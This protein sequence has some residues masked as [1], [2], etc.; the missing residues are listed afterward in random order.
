MIARF[1]REMEK[2]KKSIETNMNKHF[3]VIVA[4]KGEPAEW[5]NRLLNELWG[6]V[7]IPVLDAQVPAML[8]QAFKVRA[9]NPSLSVFLSTCLYDTPDGIV[10]P[11]ASLANNGRRRSPATETLIVTLSLFTTTTLD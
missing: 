3:A 11:S 4:S 1:N 7:V 5:L 10:C 8:E 6:N 9:A 2:V